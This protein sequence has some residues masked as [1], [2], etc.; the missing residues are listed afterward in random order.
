MLAS[1][2]DAEMSPDCISWSLFF[3]IFLGGIPPDPPRKSM[4][5][6]LSV[7]SASSSPSLPDQY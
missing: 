6:M 3:Q 7:R 4:L 5:R 1:C 2:L